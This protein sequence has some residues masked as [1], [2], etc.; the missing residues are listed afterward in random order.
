P[1]ELAVNAGVGGFAVAVVAPIGFEDFQGGF[2]VFVG[3]VGV[4]GAVVVIVPSGVVVHGAEQFL[5]LGNGAVVHG[6]IPE[7]AD[8]VVVGFAPIPVV[9]GPDHEVGAAVAHQFEGAGGLAVGGAG[10]IVF[11]VVD[12][13]A[14]ADEK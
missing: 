4:V 14:G 9:A 12:V 1:V 13:G 11:G 3:P 6:P 10:A 2:L 7:S 8:G 5:H